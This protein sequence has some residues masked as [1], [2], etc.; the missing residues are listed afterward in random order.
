MHGP[1]VLGVPLMP[2]ARIRPVG[3][4]AIAGLALLGACA[5]ASPEDGG[6]LANG[7]RL[8]QRDCGGCH[9]VEPCRQSPAADA[10]PFPRL[11]ER[12]DV[13]QLAKALEGGLMVGHPRMPLVTLD[14]DEIADLAA[15]VK[16]VQAR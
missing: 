5:T 14:A 1:Q 6:H 11:S 13:N 12:Y 2:I 4:A 3:L 7:L 8:A 9:A 16:S 15:Y 10:T